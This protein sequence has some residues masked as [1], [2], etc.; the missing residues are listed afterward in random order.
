VHTSGVRAPVTV[1][2]SLESSVPFDLVLV[3]V[4]APHV[5]AVLPALRA[6]AAR[7]VTLALTSA[8]RKS[9]RHFETRL[10]CGSLRFACPTR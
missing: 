7:K 4:L 9:S 8:P 10:R 1:A 3:T 5:E 6:S 2:T